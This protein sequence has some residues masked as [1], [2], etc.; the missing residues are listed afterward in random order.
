MSNGVNINI[1]PQRIIG[2]STTFCHNDNSGMVT[3]FYNDSQTDSFS[4]TPNYLALASTHI[5]NKKA[6]TEH[7]NDVNQRVGQLLSEGYRIVAINQVE[8]NENHEEGLTVIWY[9]RQ[10]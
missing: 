7:H 1:N 5:R 9:L 6:W 3:L 10:K 8:I 2:I 4:Q